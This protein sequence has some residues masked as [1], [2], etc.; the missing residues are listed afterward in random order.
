MKKLVYLLLLFS[1]VFTACNKETEKNKVEGKKDSSETKSS[2]NK[3]LTGSFIEIA[4]N[5]VSDAYDKRKEGYDWVSVNVK[6]AGQNEI[7]IMVRSRADKKKPTCTF[8]TKAFKV[9]DTTYSASV[10]GK[11]I[12]ITFSKTSITIQPEK[13]EDV[14]ALSFFCSGGA[15]VAGTYLKIAGVLDQDQIDKTLFSKVLTLQDVGFNI[16]AK[17]KDGKTELEIFPFG[18]KLDKQTLTQTIDGVVID[19]EVED[20]DADGSPEVVVYTQSGQDKKGNVIACSV[21]KKNSMILCY[22]PS[23]EENDKIKTGYNGND[24]FSLIERNLVQRFPVYAN[25]KESGKT[26][27]VSYTLEKGES[28][29]VFKVKNVTE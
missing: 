2:D 23:V 27:Q 24:Q 8:D 18:L 6:A 7:S 10:D 26:R 28:T 19:A 29:K 1:I 17:P 22:F 3:Q 16:T 15:T 25:G 14:A 20:L 11:K 9:N 21:L 13:K 4:G 12:N 5:Y